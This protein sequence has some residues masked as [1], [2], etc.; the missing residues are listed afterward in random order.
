M[1]NAISYGRNMISLIFAL[2][3]LAF[4]VYGI[5]TYPAYQIVLI[6]SVVMYLFALRL[7]PFLWLYVLL[8]I[9]IAVNLAPWTGRYIVDELDF[10]VAAT[11]IYFLLIN[12]KRQKNTR[13]FYIASGLVF[14]CLF[15]SFDLSWLGAFS[16]MHSN[17]YVTPL[18]G[19]VIFKGLLW[20]LLLSWVFYQQKADEPEKAL[21]HLLLAAMLGGFVMF[22]VIM[23]EKQV[24]GT[25]FS[26]ADIYTKVN[27]F[28]NLSSA[29]R[30]TGIISGMHTGGES[31]D[32]MY[33]ILLPLT[34]GAC[35]Y[36]KNNVVRFT[37]IG[38]VVGVMYG[39]L[40]G[41]TRATYAASFIA[42][43]VLCVMYFLQKW[44]SA[45]VLETGSN[46]TRPSANNVSLMMVF[47]NVISYAL[48]FYAVY[49]LHKF[50]GYYAELSAGFLYALILLLSTY[51]RVST[52]I[53]L[54][55]LL[56]AYLGFT[57]INLDS[58]QSSQW[59]DKDTV[60]ELSLYFHIALPLL[61][62]A[63]VFMFN[64]KRETD[65]ARIG[66]ETIV[67]LLVSVLL[68]AAFSGARINIRAETS[69]SDL[70]TRLEHWQ[71]IIDSGRWNTSDILFG[72]GLGTM[73]T[74]YAL[75]G[76]GELEK[77][78]TF[79]FNKQQETLTIIPGS[80]LLF[81]QRLSL[82]NQGAYLFEI[83]YKATEEVRVA[84]ALCRRNMIIFEFWAHGC[85]NIIRRTL[86]STGA[87]ES[88]TYLMGLTA[89]KDTFFG[90][91]GALTMKT[92][93]G[94]VPITIESISLLNANGEQLLKNNS[95]D[96][97]GDFWFF[98]YDFEH[99][100]W[101][102]KNLYLSFAYQF[103]VIGALLIG[104]LIVS[105][106]IAFSSKNQLL[107]L[108]AAI[109]SAFLAG[110]FAFGLFGDPL[111]SSRTN[112]WFF[113]LLFGALLPS[114]KSPPRQI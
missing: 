42:I 55:I 101:H 75:S 94:N 110:Q 32:G 13:H 113:F 45:A 37:A 17:F 79:E 34:L 74:N 106:A 10:F 2:L 91:P 56:L 30:T 4:V 92:T 105:A 22:V 11:G 66:M 39:V 14:L 69:T 63:G 88:K 95:F 28:F 43:A 41:F 84:V 104:A 89:T 65:L 20:A 9:T 61:A 21:K 64:R 51:R 3:L 108:P 100:V 93:A 25:L 5:A 96:Y 68:A 18:N 48:L 52:L 109:F 24:L 67:V 111:D 60:S 29:Y 46:A 62:F 81:S 47:G 99:L 36:F 83:A 77:I 23:W 87:D 40:M 114:H 82:D 50:A 98:Y 73:P 90:L 19:L 97:G 70:N 38:A 31:I 86:P 1:T 33:L 57:Y 15:T 26:G 6:V 72:H 102:I 71:G 8:F 54:P 44:R 85:G 12:K 49:Q 53:A 7:F 58:F 76:A 107:S 27:T 16:P 59:V 80:D 35:F 78:G 112:M 103:G